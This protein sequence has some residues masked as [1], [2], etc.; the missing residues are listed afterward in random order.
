MGIVTT[1]KD[2]EDWKKKRGEYQRQ[3]GP[4][5]AAIKGS[6]IDPMNLNCIHSVSNLL[7]TTIQHLESQL[8]TMS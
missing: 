8:Y 5:I 1:P 3:L 7:H 6:S 2:V 4:L